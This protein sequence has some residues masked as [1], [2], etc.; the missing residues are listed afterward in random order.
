MFLL[1][2]TLLGRS[3][4]QFELYVHS[5]LAIRMTDS[6][7]PRSDATVSKRDFGPQGVFKRH[8]RALTQGRVPWDGRQRNQLAIYEESGGNGGD[9]DLKPSLMRL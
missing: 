1:T 5:L 4:A 2:E 3:A 7:Q 9:R 8:K 6:G